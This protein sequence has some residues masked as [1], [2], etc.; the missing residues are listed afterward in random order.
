MVTSEKE[1]NDLLIISEKDI[2]ERALQGYSSLSIIFIFKSFF[3]G[4][5]LE[6]MR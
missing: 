5:N 3:Y 1:K 6:K 4:V 2:V